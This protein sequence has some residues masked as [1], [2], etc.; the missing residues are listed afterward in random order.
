MPAEGRRPAYMLLEVIILVGPAK[1]IHLM[2]LIIIIRDESDLG[3]RRGDKLGKGI[4]I[5][6]TDVS[7][8]NS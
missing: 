4:T 6:F 5:L 3:L 2:R 1:M 8:Q 7:T